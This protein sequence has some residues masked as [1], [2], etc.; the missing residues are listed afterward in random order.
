M[1]ITMNEQLLT[2]PEALQHPLLRKRRK[3]RSIVPSTLWRWHARGVRGVKLETVLV[4][5]M[6]MTSEEA[7]ARFC[8]AVTKARSCEGKSRH[9]PETLPRTATQRQQTSKRA[10]ARLRAKGI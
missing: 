1:L 10:E 8:E 7:L 9:A 3:G 5:G 6:R 4:G 2:F